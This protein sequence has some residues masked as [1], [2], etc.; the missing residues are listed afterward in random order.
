VS[1][2]GEIVAISRREISA[3]LLLRLDRVGTAQP[4]R[5][6]EAFDVVIDVAERLRRSEPCARYRVAP[7]DSAR[8][9]AS[10]AK[11]GRPDRRELRSSMEFSPAP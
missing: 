1:I 10:L 5:Y 8:R 9:A 7:P 11:R 4:F 2:R 3:R 6:V